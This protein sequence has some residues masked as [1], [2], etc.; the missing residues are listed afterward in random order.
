MSTTPSDKKKLFRQM[1]NCTDSSRWGSEI[2]SEVLVC[3]SEQ[4]KNLQTLSKP[5]KEM[6]TLYHNK[7]T[8]NIINNRS[9]KKRLKK[10]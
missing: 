1:P 3:M 2:E 9:N 8:E 7:T 5:P 10:D 4:K 6:T